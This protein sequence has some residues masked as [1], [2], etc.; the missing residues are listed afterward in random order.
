MENEKNIFINACGYDKSIVNIETKYINTDDE[1]TVDDVGSQVIDKVNVNLF[2]SLRQTL[3]DIT[4]DSD[5]DYN[6]V[7]TVNMLKDFSKPEN[8]L[9]MH[10]GKIPCIQCTISPTYYDGEY[11]ITFVH[12][13]WC[14]MPSKIGDKADTIR[15]IVDNDLIHCYRLNASEDNT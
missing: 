7:Q 1:E 12:A 3:I 5:T 6:F 8:G 9:N 11:Y 10:N 2:K 4:Y 14:L 15:F 13:T